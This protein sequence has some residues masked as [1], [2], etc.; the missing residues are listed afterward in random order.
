MK[1]PLTWSLV[2]LSASCTQQESQ[3]QQNPVPICQGL[4]AP[5]AHVAPELPVVTGCADVIAGD[6]VTLYATCEDR[7]PVVFGNCNAQ[8]GA[9]ICLSGR[10]T[11]I[12][13]KDSD[14]LSGF[15]CK[16]DLGVGD[17]PVSSDFGY[18]ERTCQSDT[19]CVRCD[20]ICHPSLHVCSSPPAHDPD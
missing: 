8:I 9:G 7:A 4:Q 17:V 13:R 11:T 1:N 18:C 10:R 20:L 3:V 12:C 6:P 2:F 16:S 5:A 14:C 15:R 19:D